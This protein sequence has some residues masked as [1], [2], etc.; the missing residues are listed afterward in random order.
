MKIKNDFVT[1]SSSCSF[2][3]LGFSIPYTRNDSDEIYTRVEKISNEVY[4]IPGNFF[5][6]LGVDGGARCSEEAIIGRLILDIDYYA[7]YTELT[8][9][10]NRDDVIKLAEAFNVDKDEIKYIVGSRCC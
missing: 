4:G 5:I 3:L 7:E 1:N 2:I 6:G 10:E 9:N 8:F